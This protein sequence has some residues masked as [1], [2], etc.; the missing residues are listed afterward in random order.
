MNS[1]DWAMVYRKAGLRL[2]WLILEAVPEGTKRAQVVQ[3][4]ED[5][6]LGER[7]SPGVG[8]SISIL[9]QSRWGTLTGL[10]RADR[11]PWA[12]LIPQTKRLTLPFT[13]AQHAHCLR[14]AR[15][16]GGHLQT[17]A[18][19]RLLEAATAELEQPAPGLELLLEQLEQPTPGSPDLDS[20][21]ST[22]TNPSTQF[23][24]PNDQQ[25]AAPSTAKRSTAKRSTPGR[26]TVARRTDTGPARAA[27]NKTS[28]DSV[29]EK[30]RG[31]SA[32]AE[33]GRPRKKA[34][35]TKSPTTESAA[36]GS[37]DTHSAPPPAA[38]EA[39]PAH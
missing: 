19:I 11:H 6:G 22:T 29:A 36:A 31:S 13:G 34:A 8:G 32:R 1:Q 7:Y 20:P 5:S 33:K 14:A 17:W 27:P 10:D 35:S 3:A 23:P 24:E 21:N 30:A 4:L 38:G 2:A 15:R 18:M 16:R 26:I 39:T 37:G 9:P 28:A 12:T 25:T